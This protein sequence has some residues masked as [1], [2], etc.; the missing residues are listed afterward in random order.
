MIQ[1]ATALRLGTANADRFCAASL[2]THRNTRRIRRPPGLIAAVQS[3]PFIAS[4][5][6]SQSAELFGLGDR[7]SMTILG[8][9]YEGVVELEGSVGARVHTSDG[10]IRYVPNAELT[11]IQRG[12][13]QQG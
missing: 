13:V 4:T 7:V 12:S 9:H 10:L 2:A 5:G 6:M 8:E 1:S 3:R 11:L